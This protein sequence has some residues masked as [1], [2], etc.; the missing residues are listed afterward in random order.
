[1]TRIRASHRTE[2]MGQS[3]QVR[4]LWTHGRELPSHTATAGYP[5]SPHKA[6]Q[7][8]FQAISDLRTLSSVQTAPMTFER[9]EL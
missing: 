5:I 4:A 1:M 3:L 6:L 9:I 2:S 8:L 7:A